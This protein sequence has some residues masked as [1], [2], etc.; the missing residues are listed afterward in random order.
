[1][2]LQK[3]RIILIVIIVISILFFILEKF[4]NKN[5]YERIE[6][7]VIEVE[8]EDPTNKTNSKENVLSEEDLQEEETEEVIEENVEKNK[9]YVYVTGEVNNSGVMVLNEGSRIIDAINA[10][11]GTT[12]K[13]DISKV[14]LAYVLEDG[15][16]LNIPNSEDL[17]KNPEFDY[18]TIGSSDGT[19]TNVNN[20]NTSIGR[21]SKT[22]SEKN[23]TSVININTASQTELETL[24]GIGPSL[25][26]KIIKYRNEVGKFNSIE[27]IKN[28]SGIG[29]NKFNEIKSYIC[30]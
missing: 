6:E 8:Q 23:N 3:K 28:V 17:N 1:M 19:N 4:L 12:D 29:E 20:I 16:K 18:I 26:L 11:G 13:A 27:D 7:N 10:A 24:P 5:E 14:N 22:N 30:V 25:A 21:T 9:I 2:N 15:M